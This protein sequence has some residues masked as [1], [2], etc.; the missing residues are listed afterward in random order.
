MPLYLFIMNISSFAFAVHANNN[1][2]SVSGSSYSREIHY[3]HNF[4]ANAH[5]IM[6][7]ARIDNKQICIVVEY[8]NSS[9][10]DRKRAR[11]KKNEREPAANEEKQFT[12]KLSEFFPFI[13]RMRSK[14]RDKNIISL[15]FTFSLTCVMEQS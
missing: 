6:N 10:H 8:N 14:N 5:V 15:K 12:C 1:T 2:T 4:L 11:K 3:T 13:R 9:A 7:N